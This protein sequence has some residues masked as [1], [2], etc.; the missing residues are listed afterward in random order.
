MKSK[1]FLWT[2]Y[3]IG[4]ICVAYGALYLGHLAMAKPHKFQDLW[5][6]ALAS[7]TGLITARYFLEK[8]RLLNTT[9]KK[10]EPEP[11]SA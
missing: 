6:H 2:W 10:A 4:A 8:F 1:W 11:P 3:W 9:S 5:D 7:G